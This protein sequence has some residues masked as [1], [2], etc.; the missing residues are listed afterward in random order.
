MH[1]ANPTRSLIRCAALHTRTA[2]AMKEVPMLPLHSVPHDRADSGASHDADLALHKPEAEEFT[3]PRR[4]GDTWWRQRCCPTAHV[5]R[6]YL[7][8]HRHHG[9]CA[10]LVRAI[11]SWRSFR[12]FGW[13]VVLIVAVLIILVLVIVDSG[14]DSTTQPPQG[15]RTFQQRVGWYQHQR[16]DHFSAGHH[17][18]QQWSQRFFVINKFWTSPAGR[19]VKV[20]DTSPF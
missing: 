5:N 19:C 12:L 20:D 11:C 9:S 14:S 16:L 3:R 18:S 15:W 13:L 10:R 7:D 8:D 4:R 2:V 1:A 6:D 17:A